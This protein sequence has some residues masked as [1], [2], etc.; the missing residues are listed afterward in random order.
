MV[1]LLIY[2]G[3]AETF[4]KRAELEYGFKMTEL[5]SQVARAK[6]FETYP[7]LPSG[8]RSRLTR[9]RTSI[10]NHHRRGFYIEG[11]AATR[12][13]L[14][15]LRAWPDFGCD[16]TA[17]RFMMFNS[18]DQGSGTDLL[19]ACMVRAYAELPEDHKVVGLHS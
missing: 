4:R 12:T 16:T 5:E 15:R 14:G 2:G 9:A 7:A 10:G 3:Q 19:K 1:G 18:P 13:V 11:L 17:T 8:I 6:F